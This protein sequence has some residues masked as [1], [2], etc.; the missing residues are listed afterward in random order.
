MSKLAPYANTLTLGIA[1]V[2][3]ILIAT[4]CSLLRN[5]DHP[6]LM[7]ASNAGVMKIIEMEEP[8]GQLKRARRIVELADVA[9]HMLDDEDVVVSMVYEHIMAQI[10]WDSL[11]PSDRFLL[12]GT[13]DEIASSVALSINA[14]ALNGDTVTTARAVVQRARDAAEYYSLLLDGG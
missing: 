4:G 5:G 6:V 7:M 2:A 14:N 9:L 13:L 10:R 11:A 12:Q 1:G 8:E 3:L